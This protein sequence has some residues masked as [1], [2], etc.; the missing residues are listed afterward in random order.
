MGNGY[1]INAII[2]K[3]DVMKHANESFIS[4]T[5]W[6][7]K[8]GSVAALKTLELMEKLQ[9]W[10]IIT[11][12]GKYIKNKW[13]QLSKKYKIPINI[14][15]LDALP[16]FTFKSKYNLYLKTFISQEMLKKGFLASNTI[17]VSTSHK[18]KIIDRSLQ[19]LN[20]IIENRENPALIFLQ[21]EE[22]G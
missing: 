6:T 22:I 5:F 2:G 7:E 13:F 15:G 12:T 17:Y 21:F 4:S 10:K 19:M 9:S 1:A 3:E 18:R 14:S 20:N 16:L 8:T 11:K